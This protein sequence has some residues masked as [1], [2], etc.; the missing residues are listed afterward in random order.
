[1]TRFKRVDINNE[2]KNAAPPLRGA[3]LFLPEGNQAV[4]FALFG[5][6]RTIVGKPS[7][8]SPGTPMLVLHGG[9]A[10]IEDMGSRID[11]RM[12]S[13]CR[14]FRAAAPDGP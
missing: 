9:I 4:S 10:G 2:S 11:R 8:I 14:G 3:A 7:A 6:D 5:R 1:V 12:P 13:E